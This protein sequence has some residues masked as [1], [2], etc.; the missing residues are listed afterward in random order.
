MMRVRSGAGRRSVLRN[1]RVA[2]PASRRSTLARSR[3]ATWRSMLAGRINYSWGRHAMTARRIHA[4][5]GRDGW[6]R[7]VGAVTMADSG[8]VSTG[9]LG[10][11][12]AELTSFIG[13]ER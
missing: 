6:F 11:V 4:R 5:L 10:R 13:R 3:P 1:D 9:R 8:G 2:A 7:E 12:A